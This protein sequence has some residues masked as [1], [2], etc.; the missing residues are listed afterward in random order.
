[1]SRYHGE[2]YWTEV[3]QHAK[4]GWRE[5]SDDELDAM[6][7]MRRDHQVRDRDQ[8]SRLRRSRARE[9]GEAGERGR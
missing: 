9:G 4:Y 1:M 8:R 3:R 6:D 2:Q 5:L 7:A